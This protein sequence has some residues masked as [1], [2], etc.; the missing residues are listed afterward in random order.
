MVKGIVPPISKPTPSL[1]M[2]YLPP[3]V[4][5][6]YPYPYLPVLAQSISAT[7]SIFPSF[8]TTLFPIPTTIHNVHSQLNPCHRRQM[9]SK[10]PLKKTS[11]VLKSLT[12][13]E[14][15]SFMKK[16]QK[17]KIT[18]SLTTSFCYVALKLSLLLNEKNPGPTNHALNKE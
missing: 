18:K 2:S 15:Q 8:H 14:K 16:F 17:P 9:G 5:F 1:G 4:Q 10:H 11:A 12:L 7:S 6:V 3:F 13:P